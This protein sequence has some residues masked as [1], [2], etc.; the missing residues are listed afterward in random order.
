MHGQP[1]YSAQSS[2]LEYA[3]PDAPSGGTLK[4]AAIGTF[5]T[6]NPFAIKGKAAQRLNLVYDRLMARVWDE[7]FTMYPLIAERADVAEDRSAVT[8]HLNPAARFHD[9]SPVTADDVLYSFETL[10]NEGR[11]NMRRIYRLVERAEKKDDLTVHFSFG[12]GHDQETVMI[13]AMMPV[14]SKAYWQDRDFEATTLEPPLG[15]GPYRVAEVD[16][17]RRVIYERVPDYWAAGRLTNTGHHNFERIVIDYYR[18]DSVAFEAFKAGDYDI[19][20]EADA[21]LWASGYDFPALESGAVVKEELPH[22]RPERVRAFI[23]NTRRPPFDDIRVRKALSLALDFDWLNTNI[24]H[25]QY[26]RIASV[27]PNSELAFNQNSPSSLPPRTALRQAA[28]LLKEAG[29]QVE[30]GQRVKD[31]KTLEFEIVL[32]APEDEKIALHFVRSLERVGISPR[33][34][35]LDTAAFRGRLNEYDY[36]MVL[37]HW[38]NSLSPGTEQMLYWSCEAAR[39]PSRFNYAGICKPEIDELATS[40]ADAKNRE[41]LVELARQLDHEI[42]EGHYMIPLYYAGYDMVAYKNTLARPEKTPL[43]GMVLETW[44]MKAAEG[45]NQD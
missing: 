14:L 19:R 17:G 7:P 42:M 21:G 25:S 9:G 43:Y 13:I 34:R 44:W 31:G 38:Q 15:N 26:Q 45:T 1:K 23:F 12:P 18:D 27:F 28:A 41:E 16:P 6:L 10:K 11:P 29:W 2:H 40:I 20:R 30:N 5:D 39:Q 4:Q 35:V 22:S 32:N 24:F 8:F 33:I 36:D 37:Y 3:N